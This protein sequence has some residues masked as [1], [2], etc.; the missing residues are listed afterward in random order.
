M[1][2]DDE[3]CRYTLA[4]AG[5]RSGLIIARLRRSTDGRWGFHALGVPSTG[6]MYKDSIGDMA[7]LTKVDP[8]ELQKTALRSM[9][10]TSLGAV[11]SS[12]TPPLVAP[13]PVAKDPKCCVMP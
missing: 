1:G 9:T 13:P 2:G 12:P 3:L 6:T 5:D 11:A 8:R 7:R 10:T 4:D